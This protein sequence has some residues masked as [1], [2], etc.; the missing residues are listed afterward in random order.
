[1]TR[2]E[3]WFVQVGRTRRTVVVLTR[4]EVIDVRQLVTVAE[5]TTTRRGIPVEIE[6]AASEAG[7]SPESV[8]N[9]DGIHTVAQSTLTNR[10][11]TVDDP[12]MAQVC[13]MLR[14][15]LGC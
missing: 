11:G 5:V 2:G 13:T 15:A 10:A 1:M 14:Y 8:I 12:A 7:L 4:S 3:I 9:C 6:F